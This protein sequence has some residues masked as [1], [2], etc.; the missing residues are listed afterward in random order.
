MKAEPAKVNTT[1]ARSEVSTGDEPLCVARPKSRLERLGV[2]LT[3]SIDC[4]VGDACQRCRL[5]GNCH[6]FR[7][8]VNGA[9]CT[10]FMLGCLVK[11]GKGRGGCM[12]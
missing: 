9:K 6:I 11:M 5:A 2:A 12:N 7:P 1:A 10:G 3:S 4:R 8:T